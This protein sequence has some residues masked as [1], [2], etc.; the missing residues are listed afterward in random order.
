MNIGHGMDRRYTWA[1]M[2]CALLAGL[3]IM[4]GSDVLMVCGVLAAFI[5]FVPS[6]VFDLP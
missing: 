6:D 3:A 5:A 2:L 1:D 4:S